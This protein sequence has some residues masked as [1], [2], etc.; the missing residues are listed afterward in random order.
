MDPETI[1]AVSE[2]FMYG[3]PV[4]VVAILGIILAGGE[5]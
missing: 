5:M 2:L 3:G 4:L 1:H